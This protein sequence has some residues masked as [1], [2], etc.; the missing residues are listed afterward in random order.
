MSI[1][2][3]RASMVSMEEDLLHSPRL[4]DG[5]P[6]VSPDTPLHAAVQWSDQDC[7]QFS[8][9]SDECS[10]VDLTQPLSSLPKKRKLTDFFQPTAVT[11][12]QGL[13]YCLQRYNPQPTVAEPH[14]I[15]EVNAAGPSRETA[16]S[17]RS[18]PKR[19]AVNKTYSLSQ[20]LEVLQH[21]HTS[22]EAEAARH[23]GISR[24]TIRGWKGLD[25][26]PVDRT[27]KKSHAKKGKN[28]AGAGRPL[29][30]N[31]DI[32]ME[33]CQWILEMRDLHLP[34]QRKH[35]QRKAMALIQPTQPSF[36]A[37]A[38]WL[39]KFLKR[40][41]LTLRRN[42]SIQQKLPAQLEEKL[43]SFLCDV[44]AL[45]AQH[46]FPNE[47][48]IN[49]NETPVYFDMASNSTI[50]KRGKT[51][52]VIRGTGA[53]KTAFHSDTHLHC[54]WTATSAFCYLQG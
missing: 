52:V 17:G 46:G 25:K 18:K 35:V 3:A 2:H 32:D 36:K 38:G 41:S 51:E 50:E 11:P 15:S 49:M 53:H 26:Q 48:I 30:Y 47:L 22:S 28:K 16:S 10:V 24:T 34:V 8:D 42:T 43:S 23:F 27:C 39:E 4:P 21:M 9:Q 14:N 29:S 31:E 5:P 54:C 12:R 19:S 37:S 44:K 7:G 33:L 6:G 45:R 1:L 20:T 40:H 13:P